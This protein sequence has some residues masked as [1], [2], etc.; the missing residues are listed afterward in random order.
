MSNLIHV[1]FL[2]AALF[3]A[4]LRAAWPTAGRFV[5]SAESGGGMPPL[6]AA[7]AEKEI[8][9]GSRLAPGFDMGVNTS[10]GLT[11]WLQKESENFKAAYPPGQ[12]W[13]AVFVTVGKPAAN[14]TQSVDLSSYTTLTVEMKGERGG[15]I[16]EIGIRDVNQ[17]ADGSETKLDVKL[18]NS[19]KTYH[20][21]LA[22]FI[23]ADLKRLYIVIEFVFSG[24]QAETLYF[25]NIRYL[26][27]REAADM[28]IRIPIGP[29]G[30]SEAEVDTHLTTSWELSQFLSPASQ[31]Q[32]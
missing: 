31:V 32:V 25:R 27:G 10:G 1:L 24:G 15:A 4:C 14:P 16:V 20:L 11:A 17:P 21:P 3:T 29:A 8:M 13:G 26:R 28:G 12:D 23:G 7:S 30:G 19:W 5:E 22:S 18:T 2:C 9:I 6:A